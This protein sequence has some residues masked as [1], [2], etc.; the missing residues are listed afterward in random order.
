M[1][2]ERPQKQGLY[3][4]EFEH[5]NCGIGFVAHLKGKKSHSIISKGLEI[6]CNMTH[7]GAEGSDSKTGDGAGV[8]IQVPR[9][10]YLIQGYSLPPEGQFGTG[11]VFFPQNRSDAEK[12]KDIMHKVISEEGLNLIGFREVPRDSTVIGHLSRAAEPDIQQILLGTELS[13][14]DMERKLYIVRKRIENIIRDSDMVQKNMFYIPSLSTKV[15]I[16]KGMLTSPQLGEYFLDLKDERMQ[17]AIALVHSRFSTNT[18]PS[19]D[20]AQPFRMLGHNGEINTIK[21]NRFWMEARESILKSDKLGDLSRLFPV[22]QPGMS[23]SASLDNVLEFLIMSGKSLPYAISIL[24]PESINAKNPIPTELRDFYHYHATFME[25]WDGPASLIFSDGRYIGGMLDRNGLRPS[26]YLITTS[27][28]MVMGSETGVQTFAPE[29]IREKGRLKPGKMLLLDTEEGKIYHDEELKAKLANEFPYGEWIKQNVV[30]LEEIETGQQVKPDMGDQ[31]NKY[32]TSFNYSMEDTNVIIR[33]MAATGKEPIS[34]MGNDVPLAVLSRKPYRLFNYFKQLFAQVTNPP[35]DPIREEL[36]MTLSGYLGSLQQNLLETSPDHVKMVRFR[37]PVISNTYFKVVKNLRYKGFSNVNLLLHFEADK[38]AEGLQSAVEQLCIDAEKAVDEGKNYII[39]SDR[40]I[41]KNTAPIPSLLAVSAVHHHLIKKRKRMQID[42]VVESAEPRE[43]MHFA[44]LF[45]YG[46]SIINPYMSF[47]VIDKLV[48]EK[49]IQLDYQNARDN[50]INAVNKGILKIMSKMGICTLR[51]YRSSQIFEAVG[52]HA[53]V[54]DK[55]FAGTVSRIGGIGMGEIAEEVLIPHRK[56]FIHEQQPEILTEGVFSYRKYGEHHAWNPES[57]ALLQWSTRTGNYSKFKEYSDLVNADTA[58]PGFIRGLLKIKRNP[59][60]IDEVEPVE[61]IMKRFVTGAM[62]YGSISREAHETLAIA[63]NRI[64]GRSNTGEG[65][66]DPVRFIPLENGDSARS[67]IKQVASGRFGVTTEY[68]VNADELQIKIA[69]GAKPGEGGQLPGHKVDHIIA[70]TRYSIPGITLISPPPH[71]DIYSIEDLSQLIFDLKNV[72]PR[73]RISVKLVSE[74]G[75]GTIAAGV[76]KAG[77]DLITIS[78][79]EGGTGASPTSSIKHAGLPLELGLAETQ[80]TL[81]MNNLRRKVMLQA[82]GQL[83]SGKDIIMAALM[84]AEEFGLAT[85][86]LIVLGCVMMRKCHLNTCPVGVA[87][88]DPE[89]RKRFHGEADNLVTFF[90]FIAEE[91][92]EQLAE[93]GYKKMDDIVGRLDLLERNPEIDHWKIKNLDLSGLL[94]LP[95]E[96]SVNSI[97]CIDKQDHKID[98]ILDL[99]LITEAEK[100]LSLKEPVLI[101]KTIQN[102]DRTTGAMLSGKIA[103]LY[104][105]EGLPEGTINCRFNGSAGQSFGAFL[106]PGIE[107]RLEGDS[108]DYLGKGLSGGRII[109]VPPTGSTFDSDKNIIIGNTVLYGATRG[110]IYISGI[111]GERFGVRNSGANAVVEGVGNHCCEY[112]TGGRVVVL[113]STGSNFAAGMSGGIAYVLDEK[114]DFDYYCNMGMVELSLVEDRVD[115]HEL[116]GLIARHFYFTKSKKAKM[117]LDDFEKYLPMFIK[118][119]PYDYK[120]V[121]H[122]QKLEELKKKIADVEVDL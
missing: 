36:V 6:L 12:C 72:N 121:L 41:D 62:S 75:I 8:L 30:N 1:K 39:L 76:T 98:H 67:A 113:G 94:T 17:S 60:P 58:R 109:V 110:E 73:A 101:Q 21:G 18:F 119:I 5:E 42:I 91:V 47:A 28:L 78:G 37:N 49:A 82:D 108:N 117:I 81:V 22:V 32:L 40:D 86:A 97:H 70:K 74:S 23:D 111:A 103:T 87:T 4:Q 48:K 106:M 90:R 115:V 9:D 11:L 63:M 100:A 44:L 61:N 64:G 27:D 66:E 84:G 65:G 50:Y 10:F 34:S 29:E 68:L 46:A 57:I 56:A 14:E 51:S 83:K 80:Q 7:R 2:T 19:W 3:R 55:Y 20:L 69:Q 38:G 31:F 120:K 107:L 53:D 45:G 85:S 25:P 89:L 88:Q 77:A 24:I 102:T 122:E 112:M 104:G 16:Y 43:V 95:K 59:I 92:R 105:A 114:G 71:H 15:L 35:I 93:L 33:E 79:Y 54:I 13:Q 99:E 26:R 118:I 116:N 52:V 96:S